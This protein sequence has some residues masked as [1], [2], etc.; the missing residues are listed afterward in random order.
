MPA[1]R[2]GAHHAIWPYLRQR[3]LSEMTW[4]AYRLGYGRTFHRT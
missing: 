2:G 4:C 3:G 1:F